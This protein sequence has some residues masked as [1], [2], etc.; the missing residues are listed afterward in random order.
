MIRYEFCH[1]DFFLAGLCK[2]P[3]MLFLLLLCFVIVV[4]AQRGAFW[5]GQR[6][7]VKR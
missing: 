7:E 6:S 4:T 1:R 2:D 3:L 5:E